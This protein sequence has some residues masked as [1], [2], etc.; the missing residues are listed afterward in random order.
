MP[1]LRNFCNILSRID[2]L[3][4]QLTILKYS[5]Q[6]KKQKVRTHLPAF[7]REPNRGF[8]IEELIPWEDRACRR[9]FGLCWGARY[10]SRSSPRPC[11][12]P[13]AHSPPPP[14][15]ERRSTKWY[16]SLKCAKKRR[17]EERALELRASKRTWLLTLPSL[18]CL[19]VSERK[20]PKKRRRF[21]TWKQIKEL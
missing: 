21:T 3:D 4:R 18:F 16:A 6:K 12:R 8:G 1:H 11:C 9:P 17:R 5:S 15:T 10:G 7:S 13:P 19:C 2:L 14:G 20:K